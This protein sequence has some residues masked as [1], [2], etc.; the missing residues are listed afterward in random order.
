MK[1]GEKTFKRTKS[2]KCFYRVFQK[3]KAIY[4][5]ENYS[6]PKVALVTLK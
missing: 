3:E 4:D 6:I 1:S 2:D 5:T